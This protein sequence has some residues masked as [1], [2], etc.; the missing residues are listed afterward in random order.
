[1][2][3]GHQERFSVDSVK[4]SAEEGKRE[5][6]E[7]QMGQHSQDVHLSLTAI[8]WSSVLG[9]GPL[10]RNHLVVRASGT[11]LDQALQAAELEL[12]SQQRKRPISVFCSQSN[13]SLR[14]AGTWM[15]T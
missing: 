9:V 2:A 4:Y 6:K 13:R 3:S 14:I 8:S 11:H 7:G 10:F 1:M 12:D 15:T 5:Q